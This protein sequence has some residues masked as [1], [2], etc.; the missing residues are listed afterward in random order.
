MSTHKHFQK[1]EQ[2]QIKQPPSKRVLLT[3]LFAKQFVSLSWC[4]AFCLIWLI[5]AII[6]PIDILFTNIQQNTQQLAD[7]TSPLDQVEQIELDTAYLELVNM[8]GLFALGCLCINTLLSIG[9]LAKNISF[10]RY[11]VSFG[12][13]L[14][15]MIVFA[16]SQSAVSLVDTLF[17]AIVSIVGLGICAIQPIVLRKL[18]YHIGR[19]VLVGLGL[20][21][22]LICSAGIYTVSL[23]ISS[24]EF[25]L[26]VVALPLLVWWYFT[27]SSFWAVY[28]ESLKEL[29]IWQ[30]FLL[31]SASVMVCFAITTLVAIQWAIVCGVLGIIG[32][33][34]IQKVF[35]L[36]SGDVRYG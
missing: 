31:F 9:L 2:P 34:I 1:I 5:P 36:S 3:A 28:T 25:L 19:S 30:D 8:L 29:F 18:C 14:L 13:S 35:K 22:A 21:F 23:T 26:I 20:L 10:W 12:C 16:G 17:L 27:Q 15:A 4:L 33:G 11:A 32:I 6:Q 7:V 24:G